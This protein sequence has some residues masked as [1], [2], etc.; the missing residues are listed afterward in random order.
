MS[1]VDELIALCNSCLDYL[2][3]ERQM[4]L[5]RLEHYPT[6]VC[7]ADALKEALNVIDGCI[8]RLNTKRGEF[9]EQKIRYI[10][11]SKVCWTRL[12]VKKVAKW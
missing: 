2:A 8:D 7:G 9:V 5:A 3:Q 11:N 10:E 12:P 1:K 4:Y 6:G